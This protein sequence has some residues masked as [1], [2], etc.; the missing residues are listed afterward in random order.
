MNY[1]FICAVI[2]IKKPFTPIFRKGIRID[3]VTMI[4]GGNITSIATRFYTWLILA[5][6]TK[7]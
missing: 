4:L 6:M 2:V 1:S 7:F 5:S 3:S